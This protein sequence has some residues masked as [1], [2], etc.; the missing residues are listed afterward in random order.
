MSKIPIQYLVFIQN[1]CDIDGNGKLEINAQKNGQT[2]DEVSIFNRACES[3]DEKKQTVIVNNEEKT[4]GELIRMF[5]EPKNLFIERTDAIS[6]EAKERAKRGASFDGMVSKKNNA[7]SNK[8]DIDRNSKVYKTAYNYAYSHIE[9]HSE[10]EKQEKA[11]KMTDLVISKCQ[12]YDAEELAPVIIQ[13]LK[14]ECDYDFSKKVLAK[15]AIYM[16]SGQCTKQTL[17]VVVNTS[18]ATS[19]EK[20][21]HKNYLSGYGKEVEALKKQYGES[22]KVLWEKLKTDGELGVEVAIL[23]ILHNL[24]YFN[25]EHSVKKAL[26]KYGDDYKKNN[27]NLDWSIMPDTFVPKTGKA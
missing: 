9:A 25:K 1:A 14:V 27:K 6:T 16:G 7:L 12:K 3:Y 2:Y 21:E 18:D 23:T 4:I 10:K 8:S 19:D 20:Y 26:T 22:K 5:F 11:T 13:I 17:G 15:N 24:N